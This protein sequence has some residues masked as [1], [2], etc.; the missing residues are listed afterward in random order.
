MLIADA[1]LPITSM[2]P[3]S[4]SLSCA[5]AIARL[6]LSTSYGSGLATRHADTIHDTPSVYHVLCC[7]TRG[8]SSLERLPIP[9]R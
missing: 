1:I 6:A 3:S 9:P 2:I 8:E 5:L 4:A 7:K